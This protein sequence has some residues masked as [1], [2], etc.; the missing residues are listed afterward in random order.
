MPL[1]VG[2]AA[3]WPPFPVRAGPT[4]TGKWNSSLNNQLE[5]CTQKKVGRCFKLRTLYLAAVVGPSM[6][7]VL[8]ILVLAAAST[9]RE[10]SLQLLSLQRV[11]ALIEAGKKISGLG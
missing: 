4:P 11:T 9:R 2:T 10:K 7:I 8:A 5:V 6:Q 3:F 1:V